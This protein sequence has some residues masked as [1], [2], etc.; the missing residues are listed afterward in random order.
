MRFCQALVLIKYFSFFK[1]EVH[2]IYNILFVSGV[3][4]SDSVF[5]S[6]IPLQVITIYKA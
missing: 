2:S 5:C 1:I 6:Y 3:Q 4:Q